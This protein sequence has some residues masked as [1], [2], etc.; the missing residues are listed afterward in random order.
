MVG[1]ILVSAT[2]L[3]LQ[4]ADPPRSRHEPKATSKVAPEVNRGEALAEYNALRAKTPETAVAQWRLGTWCE[5]HGLKDVA[6][7]HFAEV[8]R[9]D[10]RRD[11]AW[12]K[13]GFKKHG[14]H[15]TNDEQ[16]AE[17]NEQKKAD[18]VWGPKLSKLHKDIHG[19]NG[20]KKRHA[21]QAD[22]DAIADPRAV[23]CA[24]REFCGGGQSD[25]NILIQI[26]GQ[27]DRPM[28]SKVLALLAVYGKTPDVRRRATETLR[29]RSPEDFLDILV[30]LMTDE[31]K[32]E[33]RPVG[34]PGSP[35][36]LFVE[37]EKFN[38]SRFYAPPPPP[39]VAPQP[40]DIIVYDQSG[41]PSIARPIAETT[42]TVTHGVPGSKT[43]VRSTT[44]VNQQLA[45][46]S[47]Y[48]LML[49]AQRGAAMAEAQLEGDVA[50]IK[51][52]NDDRKR[53]NNVIMA[54][55]KDATGKDHGR[56]PKEW[57]EALAAGSGSPKKADPSKPTFPEMVP[58]AYNPTFMPVGFS[59]RTLTST[60]VFVD[61]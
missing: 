8:V 47:P 60:R 37:G 58:L 48:Q 14:G 22:V 40:G 44:T 17:E 34:G 45:E 61:S 2:L 26:M 36:V 39:N 33:V 16:I 19:T 6:Y 57:R 24:Y 55:A 50:L 52:I 32:Y 27:I 21:A 25:Q 31:F 35:G 43:L 12:R 10:P 51:S 4:V 20:A 13:L 5:E 46:I 56:T 3:T 53:F 49:E 29:G 23:L 41:M 59:T 30:G 7:V 1:S 38:V 18:K 54:I 11:A 42:N 15:W 9:L 28:S